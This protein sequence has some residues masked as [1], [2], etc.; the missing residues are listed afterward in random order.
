MLLVVDSAWAGPERIA[1]LEVNLEHQREIQVSGRLIRGLNSKI[2]ED[3][4]NGIPKELYFYI[5]LKRKQAF[6]FDE[7]LRSVTVKYTVKYDLL[8]KQFMVWIHQN[9][10]VQQ[11]SLE[12]YPEL[13]E[14]I[15]RLD[16][17]R[18]GTT[19]GLKSKHTYFVSVKA[20]MKAPRLPLYLDYILFFIPFLEL[21]TPWADSAPF[22]I[23]N[24]R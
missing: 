1:D 18:I 4:E 19:E 24:G 8:K 10:E 23:I 15:S 21:E 11:R 13:A 5:V 14:L 16:H 7:E 3:I 9:G 17:V 20:E 2:R 6:W 22:Y 12:A